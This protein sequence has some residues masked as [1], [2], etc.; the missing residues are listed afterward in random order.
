MVER[1]VVET[2]MNRRKVRMHTFP[3]NNQGL[4]LWGYIQWNVSVSS[5]AGFV[6]TFHIGR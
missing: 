4:Q 5:E 2:N 6:Y 1:S 3:G